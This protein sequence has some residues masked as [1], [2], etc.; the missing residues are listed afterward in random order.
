MFKL[1]IDGHTGPSS[2]NAYDLGSASY[3]WRNLYASNG[4]F[5]SVSTTNIDALGY[6]STT[7]LYINGSLISGGTPTLQDVTDE[8]YVTTNPIRVAGASSTGHILPVTTLT[9]DLGSSSNRWKDLWVSSTY[10][11][12]ATWNLRQSA[13]G[14]FTI[15]DVGGSQ[16]VT[17]DT[18]GNLGIGTAT[19]SERLVV[20][21]NIRL[22]A[23]GNID[24]SAAGS[25]TI[26]G[27]TQNTLTVGR[28]GATT[29]LTGSNFTAGGIAY[30]ASNQLTFTSAGTAGM[31]VLSGGTGAPTMGTLGLTYGGTNANLSGVAT[32]GLLY[33]DATAIAGT[34][35][36]TGVLKG[37]GSSAPSAM[38]G[39]ANRV[40]YWSDAN[41]LGTSNLVL[42]G[43]NVY[44]NT[45]GSLG[46]SANRFSDV[47][48]SGNVYATGTIQGGTMRSYG[49][50]RVDGTTTLNTVTYT[51]PG[52]SAN[53]LLRNTGG[54]I[55]WDTST[56]LT[57]IAGQA[58]A[59]TN[60]WVG[61]ASNQATAVAMSGDAT[62]SNTGVVTVANDSHTH[63]GTTIS[64]LAVA[65]FTSSNISNWT[66]DAGY[67]TSA[68][69]FVQ[70][71]NSFTADAVLGTND[72]YSL[73]FET[74]GVSRG[75]F[76][77]AGTFY[78]PGS[79]NSTRLAV[80]ANA[81][82]TI[83]NPL[84]Q[85]QTSGGAELARIHADNDTNL[86]AGYLSGSNN[87]ASYNAFFGSQSGAGNTTGQRNTAM[88]WGAMYGNG[89]TYAGSSQN[90]AIGHYSQ[91]NIAGGA[92]D[93][94]SVGAYSMVNLSSGDYNSG[95][96]SYALNSITTVS[97][98]HLRAHETVLDLVCRLLLEKKNT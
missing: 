56:Y 14:S 31:A 92:V 91:Y 41:T 54:T 49:N 18:S 90:V 37:N 19:M 7:D 29:A 66:N 25:L 42:S 27:T 89:L 88:G 82:Q 43:N 58:L 79:A 57:A 12:P 50:L 61:N 35:A 15:A 5:T 78:L 65:D 85:L 4:V 62:M 26:G 55:S 52:A 74:A 60:L 97:Y 80:R 63:N 44:P 40:S 96:G 53:G 20:A 10:I 38:T 46:L 28:S 17:V 59:S 69:A 68:N 76:D 51:W 36:L 13:A 24:T 33:K 34:G 3:R 32:G 9:Y 75:V 95:L 48:L 23:N 22:Q 94:A 86:F 93:N 98:T 16:R 73:F 72:G 70:N 30:G 6:V 67:L 84:I 21:G 45:A 81:S 11:G 1:T 39:T 8:G 87:S 71:G 47:F 83:A 2:T 64:G 77:T